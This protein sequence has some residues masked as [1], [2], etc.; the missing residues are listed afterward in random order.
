MYFKG[1]IDAS[2]DAGFAFKS[3]EPKT[4][5]PACVFIHHQR[6]ITAP[7]KLGKILPELLIC[8]ILAD[9]TNKNLAG[10]FL[11]IARNCS[12]GIN[13]DIRVSKN[14]GTSQRSGYRQGIGPTI[15]PSR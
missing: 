13:L 14:K 6:G 11:F 15:L 5:R 4:S 2:I 1:H 12:L 9:S 10:L 3:N 7:T 8:S